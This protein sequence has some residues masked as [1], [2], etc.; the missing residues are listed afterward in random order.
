MLVVLPAR[1]KALKKLT[2]S[3]RH[4]GR[5]ACANADLSAATTS[6]DYWSVGVNR[7]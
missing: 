7:R 3:L 1:Q 2:D 5:L 4:E 6:T